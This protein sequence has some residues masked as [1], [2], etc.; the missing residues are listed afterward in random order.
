MRRANHSATPPP[1]E[2]AAK[3][4]SGMGLR[5]VPRAF[6][7]GGAPHFAADRHCTISARFVDG[8]GCRPMPSKTDYPR[9]PL[10]PR[11]TPF[12]CDSLL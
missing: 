4:D 11:N 6:G 3:V 12:V 10:F 9:L 5:G 2:E 7:A 8:F 1:K